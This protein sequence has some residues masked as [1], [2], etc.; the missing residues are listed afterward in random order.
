MTDD[1]GNHTFEWDAANRLVA[2]NYSH[3]GD[4]TEFAYDGLSRRTK[5]VESDGDTKTFVWGG[6]TIAEERDATGDNVTKRFF[7]EGE[8]RLGGGDAGNYYYSRDHLGSVREVTDASGTV[9]A[10][11][12]YDAWGNQVVVTGNMSFDFGYTGHYRHAA[13]NLYLA[14]Y[15]AYDPAMGRWISRDPIAENG[16]FNLYAYVHNNSVNQWDPLGLKDILVGVVWREYPKNQPTPESNREENLQNSAEVRSML[17]E[18]Y[19]TAPLTGNG[20]FT[21][22]DDT[23]YVIDLHSYEQFLDTRCQ[24]F[25]DTLLFIHGERRPGYPDTLAFGA[26]R[27]PRA[28]L[29][30][31]CSA[32]GCNPQNQGMGGEDV[33]YDIYAAL[34]KARGK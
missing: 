28:A 24:K 25:D 29:P 21:V 22:G 27:V 5:I 15:R 14:L 26:D 19:N 34:Q 3:S 4:R 10:Q 8:Q 9:Q 13:S 1:G 30:P 6:N 16:G 32:F 18:L 7:A 23:I 2:I 17:A 20:A 11:Y 12:D 31:H 33:M